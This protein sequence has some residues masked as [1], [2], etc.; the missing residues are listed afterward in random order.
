MSQPELNGNK[1]RKRIKKEGE[2]YVKVHAQNS[3]ARDCFPGKNPHSREDPKKL[4]NFAEKQ[5]WN[6]K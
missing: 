6:L 4:K 2:K 3:I 1:K 5:M